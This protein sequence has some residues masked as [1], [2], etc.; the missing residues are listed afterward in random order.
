L[1]VY[2]KSAEQ[3]D[4]RYLNLGTRW[5]SVASLTHRPLYPW[6]KRPSYPLSK[7]LGGL[8]FRSGCWREEKKSL[9]AREVK[10]SSCSP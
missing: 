9:P 7:R 10:T 5:S 8:Q 2:I 1:R 6:G 3:V 4:F